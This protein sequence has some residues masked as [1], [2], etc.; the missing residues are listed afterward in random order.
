MTTPTHWQKIKSLFHKVDGLP[1]LDQMAQLEAACEGDDALKAEVAN[2]LAPDPQVLAMLE[3][4]KFSFDQ[5]QPELELPMTLEDFTVVEKIGAGG[6][7]TVYRAI[8]KQQPADH[9][10][11]VK[12]LRKGLFSDTRMRYFRKEFE[13]LSYLNHPNIAKSYRA[14]LLKD[15]QPYIVMEFVEGLPLHRYAHEK[16]LTLNQRIHLFLQVCH[17][18]TYAHQNLVVHRDLKPSNIL[19]TQEGVVKLLDFG[20]AKIL[21]QEGVRDM[22]TTAPGETPYTFGYASPEQVMGLST[23][24]TS[25]VYTL[26]ILLYE[27][28]TGSRPMP[29]ASP[30]SF[31]GRKA[32]LLTDPLKPSKVTHLTTPGDKEV[33][34]PPIEPDFHTRIGMAPTKLARA[35]KGDLDNIVMLA[36][37]KAPED[38]Y[39]SVDQM[40]GDLDRHLRGF[41]ISVGTNSGFYLLGKWIQRH[42]LAFGTALAGLAVTLAFLVILAIQNRRIG[43][44]WQRAEMNLK[45]SNLISSYLLKLFENTDPFL[46][47]GKNLEARELLDRGLDNLEPQLTSEPEAKAAILHTMA[48]AYISLSLPETAKRLYEEAYQL[49][50]THLGARHPE[51]A[52]TLSGLAQIYIIENDL[53][54]AEAAILQVLDIHRETLGLDQERV[55]SLQADL[56]QIYGERLEFEKAESQFEQGLATLVGKQSGQAMAIRGNLLTRFARVLKTKGDLER[57]ES[58]YLQAI[59]EKQRHL[60][61]HHPGLANAYNDLAVLYRQTDR[62]EDAEPYLLKSYTLTESA[63]GRMNDKTI[64]VASNLATNLQSQGRVEE[65]EAIYEDLLAAFQKQ[66]EQ[67]PKLNLLLVNNLATSLMNRNQLA[68][69]EYWLLEGMAILDKLETPPAMYKLVIT[70]NLAVLYHKQN[71][72]WLA[73]PLFESAQTTVTAMFGEKHPATA[74]VLHKRALA[75]AKAGCDAQAEDAFNRSF[76]IRTEILGPSHLE[77]VTGFFDLADFLAHHDMPERLAILGTAWKDIEAANQ[78]NTSPRMQVILEKTA[79]LFGSG[80]Q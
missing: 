48:G 34:R 6:M 47:D 70:T 32:M 72:F 40:S 13:I 25:D 22:E 74:K 60:G 18:V 5:R 55:A 79:A 65:A 7:G 15:G 39:Q 30:A 43:V 1:A 14:G 24:T 49:R 73:D 77:T 64:T 51:T 20:I 67:D 37:Q 56:G 21:H 50:K 31:Q 76:Q 44:Q 46:A 69:A 17:A 53:E 27:L 4:N 26:G 41:P 35:L 36:M 10:V 71:R 11:A 29:S 52:D 61:N 23:S 2:L 54:K 57:A 38:R 45:R 62:L 78:D 63:F 3:G 16:Q 12:V 68:D 58:Y 75:M 28:L 33:T 9:H 8:R 42:R 66:P 80:S 19:V 59:E